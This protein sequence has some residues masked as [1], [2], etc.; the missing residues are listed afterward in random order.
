MPLVENHLTEESLHETSPWAYAPRNTN[1]QQT[2]RADI[3][4]F[5]SFF[6]SKYYRFFQTS[7]E[8]RAF[9]CFRFLELAVDFVFFFNF[10]DIQTLHFDIFLKFFPKFSSFLSIIKFFSNF[11]ILQT[12]SKFCSYKILW[13]LLTF[14]KS[15]FLF[16]Q[17]F[18]TYC[19]RRFS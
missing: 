2:L 19:K 11:Q 7:Y 8:F 13:N 1:Q 5:S 10:S 4:W 14:P 12:S 6:V 18:Q 3:Y 17:G 15:S 9:R 16:F